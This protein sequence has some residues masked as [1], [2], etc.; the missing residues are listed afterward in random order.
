M[1]S[2]SIGNLGTLGALFLGILCQGC[3]GSSTAAP[4][5]RAA[6][7]DARDVNLGKVTEGDFKHSF[8]IRNTTRKQFTLTTI[9]KS[10]GCQTVNVTEGTIVP[11]GGV[12]EIPYIVPGYGS[13]PRSGRLV[14]TTD[15]TE[16][17]LREIVLTL[18]ADV[19]AQIWATPAQLL[20]G[21]VREGE[22]AEQELR[23]DSVVTG[24]LEN[25]RDATTSRGNV[26]VELKQKTSEALIFRVAFSSDVPIGAVFDTINLNFDDVVHP[27]FIVQVRGQKGARFAVIPKVITLSQFASEK[28]Q[29]RRVRVMS[30]PHGEFRIRRIES[31]PG[32][33]VEAAPAEP[34]HAVD[35]T[36]TFVKPLQESREHLIVFHTEPEGKVTMSVKYSDAIDP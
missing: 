13:G 24:L 30:V 28:T 9:H 5:D 2:R 19:Q 15:A 22:A 14:I 11:A 20:F 6:V 12:L 18:R 33:T 21:T 25:F 17:S 32:I 8:T 26:A 16:E 27:Q 7:D 4:V 35:L 23:I 10:C 36:V 1:A 34:R 31:A 3:A 29:T